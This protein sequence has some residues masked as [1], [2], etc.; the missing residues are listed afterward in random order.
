MTWTSF[1]TE[2]GRERICEVSM[3]VPDPISSIVGLSVVVV[4]VVVEEEA[5]TEKRR[6]IAAGA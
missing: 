1:D 3:P 5:R 6:S 2:I 4:A